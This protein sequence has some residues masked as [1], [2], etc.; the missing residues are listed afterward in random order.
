MDH[1]LKLLE[2]NEPAAKAEG[3]TYTLYMLCRRKAEYLMRLMFA[4]TVD[5]ALRNNLD[6]SDVITSVKECTM[7]AMIYTAQTLLKKIPRDRRDQE[8]EN[9][10]RA[11]GT[12][13]NTAR[14]L[15]N[16]DCHD[17]TMP[18]DIDTFFSDNNSWFSDLEHCTD[19][20][21]FS[22]SDNTKYQ[23]DLM[24]IFGERENGELSCLL[25]KNSGDTINFL[26]DLRT[27]PVHRKADPLL[28]GQF[29]LRVSAVDSMSMKFYRLTPFI[30]CETKPISFLLYQSVLQSLS[31]STNLKY[32]HLTEGEKREEYC[33]LPSLIPEQRDRGGQ[34]YIYTTVHN[35]IRREIEINLRD[36]NDN[37][38]QRLANR[39]S[40]YCDAICPQWKEVQNYCDRR[41]NRYCVISGE[42]GLGKTALVLHIINS[43]ILTG[44]SDY[45]RVIFLSAKRF[46]PVYTRNVYDDAEQEET[47]DLT[48]YYDFLTQMY[49]LLV[50]KKPADSLSENDLENHC[51]EKI[52]KRSIP[53]ATLL[54]IDDLDSLISKDPNQNRDKYQKQVIDFINRIE[55]PKVFSIITTRKQNTPGP[56]IQLSRLNAAGCVTFLNWYLEYRRPGS[57]KE[58]RYNGD[59]LL[60]ITRGRPYDIQH[61]ANLLLIRGDRIDPE[62][63]SGLFYQILTPTQRTLY[64]CRTSLSQLDQHT[65]LLF[66]FLCK[67]NTAL[68]RL[69]PD[70]EVEEQTDGTYPVRAEIPIRLLL[71]LQFE[72]L[73]DDDA[74][75]HSL[76]TL[77][78][79]CLLDSDSHSE[80]VKVRHDITYTELLKHSED[81]PAMPDYL[82]P[83][84][85]RMEAASDPLLWCNINKIPDVLLPHLTTRVSQLSTTHP[86]TIHE[87]C[88][89][90]R[91]SEDSNNLNEIQKKLLRK[92]QEEAT[93]NLPPY[94][95]HQV[96][97]PPPASPQNIS[98]NPPEALS[99]SDCLE[100]LKKMSLALKNEPDSNSYNSIYQKLSEGIRR[101][102]EYTN[103]EQE[104]EQLA[105]FRR[106]LYSYYY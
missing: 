100:D 74:L 61:L 48:S 92:A 32:I 54:I 18:K 103:T 59:L 72:G 58:F 44:K 8:Y 7:G 62:H 41:P 91:I 77:R 84:L 29:Y 68:C 96:S 16:D 24:Y 2:R 21:Y 15:R 56:G 90:Q 17:G 95:S 10:V 36:T 28:K 99:F 43:Y 38:T 64:L 63:L 19:G 88:I 87:A 6:T 93:K 67:A 89:I 80:T 86:E 79:V 5:L 50:G 9:L 12:V 85:M 14:V 97:P 75:H 66:C 81:L 40:A 71:Y 65:Q 1:A 70:Q 102:S 22:L 31:E 73:E 51:L 55:S 69:N 82:Q 27:C 101:L 30:S 42:G 37:G 23:Y 94:P 105:S 104:K 45:K 11:W 13:L 53:E 4:V 52:R 76:E 25:I 60:R 33:S 106:M 47:P 83:L 20:M 78:N 98:L 49:R 46:Y 39:N 57:S 26:T 3:D 35:N 34:Y